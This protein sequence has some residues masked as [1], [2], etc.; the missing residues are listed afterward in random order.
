LLCAVPILVPR[1]GLCPNSPA[2][3]RAIRHIEFFDQGAR[4]G[5]EMPLALNSSAMTV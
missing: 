4:C 3:C 2:V 5:G 1:S